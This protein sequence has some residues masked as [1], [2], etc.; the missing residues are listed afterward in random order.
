[1][2]R[3]ALIFLWV[4]SLSC[5]EPGSD[6]IDK[7]TINKISSSKQFYFQRERHEPTKSE[8]EKEELKIGPV[9]GYRFVV[10]GD[11]DGDGRKENLTE[12]FYSKKLD[13]ECCKFYDSLDY[14]QLVAFTV[15][16]E[17]FSFV[18]TDN[19]KID[20]LDIGSELPLLGLTFMKNEGDLDGNG[21]DEISYVVNVADWSNCNTCHIVT[22]EKNSWKELYSFNVWDWQFPDLPGTV[23]Q[24]VL[25]G[26]D[27]KNIFPGIINKIKPG[28]FT[29]TYHN[30]ETGLDTLTVKL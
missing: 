6:Y 4:T 9:F 24:N 29:I 14:D 16:K 21:T 12:H 15:S 27:E 28:V 23:N 19:N 7:G 3:I 25:L 30:F 22:Y 18:T 8:I 26:L 13:R 1:M 20:T 2:F 17:P 10:E 5:N 11:F